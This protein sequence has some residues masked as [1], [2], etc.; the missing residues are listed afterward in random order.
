MLLMGVAFGWVAFFSDPRYM[1]GGLP[2][3]ADDCNVLLGRTAF[4]FFALFFVW[5]GAVAL[6]DAKHRPE[7]RAE[8]S[9]T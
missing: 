2:F 8:G 1:R 7:E 4:G 5:I 3:L 6:R 9:D